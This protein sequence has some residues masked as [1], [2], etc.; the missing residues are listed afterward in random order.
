[1]QIE[2]TTAIA[3]KVIDATGGVGGLGL[4]AGKTV[5]IAYCLFMMY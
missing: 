1:V 3:G 4:R 5:A 2:S